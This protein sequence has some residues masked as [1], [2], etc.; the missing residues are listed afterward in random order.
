MS[1]TDLRDKPKTSRG[2]MRVQVDAPEASRLDVISVNWCDK[3]TWYPKATKVTDEV[4]TEGSGTVFN[5]AEQRAYVDVTHG[6]LTGENVLRTE[7]APVVKV[8]EVVT[9]ENSPGQTDN[10]YS[11]DYTTGIVTFNASQ[12]GK[13]VKVTYHYV[14]TSRTSSSPTR[15]SSSSTSV[16]TPTAPRRS[17]RRCTTTSTSRRSPIRRSPR[18]GEED[19]AA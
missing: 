15:S 5:P 6:K 11:I 19:G 9:T 4:Y 16:E 8:D 17:T 7:Y 18:W 14:G 10:D 13:T 12:T 2:K 3:T 1:S